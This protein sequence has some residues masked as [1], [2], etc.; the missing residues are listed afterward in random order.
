MKKLKNEKGAITILVLVSILF[1]VSFLISSYAIVANKLKTQKEMIS[2]TREIYNSTKSME[3]IYNSFFIDNV[4]PIYTVDQL[5]AIGTETSIIIN[6]EYY[7]FSNNDSTMYMLMN[8][9]SFNAYDYGEEYYWVPINDRQDLL[10]GFNGN[11]HKIEVKYKDSQGDE[12]SVI[13]SEE[14]NFAEP[15]YKV[16]VSPRILSETGEIL[17]EAIIYTASNNNE[18]TAQDEKGEIEISI[19]RLVTTKIYAG[20]EGYRNSGIATITVKNPNK[21]PEI[22]LVL[23]NYS[24]TINAMPEDAKVTI[25]GVER[26]TV[27]VKKGDEV[28]WKVEAKNYITQEG[29]QIIDE[30]TVLDVSLNIIKYTITVNPSPEDSTVIISSNGEILASGEGKQSVEV[31]IGTT[32]D[33]SVNRMYYYSKEGT[34][35]ANSNSTISVELESK[36][37]QTLTLAKPSSVEAEDWTN[38]DNADDGI[39]STDYAQSWNTDKFYLHY[40]ASELNE[41]VKITNIL[42]SYKLKQTLSNN[43][44]VVILNAGDVEC[45]NI[46]VEGISTKL[47]G[48]VYESTASV[49]PTGVD[50]KKG[51]TLSINNV[52]GG[53]DILYIYGSQLA[54]TYIEP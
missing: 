19:K 28:S 34:T 1:M 10:A 41:N 31:D 40:D 21:I 30:D 9:L 49:L 42:V 50:V 46:T 33:Y 18:F 25:N 39:N 22:S 7:N 5:L 29:S 15:E 45:I 36:P 16:K 20:C 37:E 4:I 35:T 54:I 44:V 48:T 51:L 27:S 12:Y 14:S 43:D 24:F 8:D 38:I 17:S 26:S 52:D 6:G 53:A 32:I 2:Q 47:G 23:G 13:Y 11:K 3:E